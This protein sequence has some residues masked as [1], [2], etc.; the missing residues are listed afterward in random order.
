[1][2]GIP[3]EVIYNQKG[4]RQGDPLSPLNFDQAADALAIMLDNA[5]KSGLVKGVLNGY[6]PNG[7]NMLQYADDTIFLLQDDYES[8]CNLKYIICLFDQ[9]SGL[10]IYFHKSEIFLFGAAEEKNRNTPEFSHAL[11]VSYQ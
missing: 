6:I 11:W 10:K 1:M 4:L 2:N 5:R 8:A 7:V 3:G 9:M